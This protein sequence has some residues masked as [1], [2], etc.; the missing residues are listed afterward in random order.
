LD[1]GDFT[2]VAFSSLSFNI[3]EAYVAPGVAVTFGNA[4]WHSG[5]NKDKMYLGR[6]IGPLLEAGYVSSL[7]EAVTANFFLPPI[8]EDQSTAVWLG[9]SRFRVAAKWHEIGIGPWFELYYA[10]NGVQPWMAV[11]C[12]IGGH[13][14]ANVA[15]SHFQLYLGY[16]TISVADFLGVPIDADF[17]FRA[18]FIQDF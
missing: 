2:V 12:R 17:V 15:K 18:S 3:G 9:I 14:L 6:E 7:I 5:P 11:E 13:I 1:P 16:N 4:S 10:K 8:Q